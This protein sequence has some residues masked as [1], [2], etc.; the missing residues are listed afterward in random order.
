MEAVCLAGR[1]TASSQLRHQNVADDTEY[2]V[3]GQPHAVRMGAMIARGAMLMTAAVLGAGTWIFVA[4]VPARSLLM[5][6]RVRR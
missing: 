5:D 4:V 1:A 2:E 6:R 3:R